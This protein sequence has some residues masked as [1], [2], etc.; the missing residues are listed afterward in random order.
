MPNKRDEN[1]VNVNA[2]LNKEAKDALTVIAARSRRSRAQTIELLV[3][4]EAHRLLEESGDSKSNQE[5]YS[6]IEKYI[7]ESPKSDDQ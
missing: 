5:L 7:Q 2:W 4:A 3:M 1:K 6:L